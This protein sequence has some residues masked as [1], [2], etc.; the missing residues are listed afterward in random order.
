MAMTKMRNTGM[1]QKSIRP[2]LTYPCLFSRITNPNKTGTAKA[3]YMVGDQPN[4]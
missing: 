3:K 2:A 1:M 4:K